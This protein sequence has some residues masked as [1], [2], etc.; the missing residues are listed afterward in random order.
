MTELTWPKWRP[1]V[2]TVPAI[3]SVVFFPAHGCSFLNKRGGGGLWCHIQLLT[4]NVVLF[5][6][7][8]YVVKYQQ[9]L[10]QTY[11]LPL[12]CLREL[13]QRRLRSSKPWCAIS[14]VWLSKVGVD[15]KLELHCKSFG[16]FYACSQSQ[17]NIQCWDY[18][19]YWLLLMIAFQSPLDL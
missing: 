19:F 2:S 5:I 10:N 14:K 17:N 16:L 11:L 4:K 8:S 3:Q 13:H 7:G 9:E 1:C 12:G 18:F 6:V 15:I